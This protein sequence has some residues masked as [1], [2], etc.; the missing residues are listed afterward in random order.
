MTPR[1]TGP[2]PPLQTHGTVRARP[3]EAPAAAV[4]RLT[5]A[6]RDALRTRM[7][8]GMR[9][10]PAQPGCTEPQFQYHPSYREYTVDGTVR[11]GEDSGF[12]LLRVSPTGTDLAKPDCQQAYNTLDCKITRFPD[13]SAAV[14][15]KSE[16]APG[17]RQLWVH[18]LRPDGTS[19]AVVT[20]NY[21][22]EVVS[23]RAKITPT[24]DQ[25]LLTMDQLVT[26]ARS[27][28]LTLYP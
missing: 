9:I 28:G 11:R 15:S 6:L 22:T 23:N 24:A 13:G 19:V 10:E 12:F 3:N 25:P 16:E 4:A 26:L 8:A 1:P 20:N 2:Q 21:R 7:P 18:L 17:A 14:L 5:G 27:P